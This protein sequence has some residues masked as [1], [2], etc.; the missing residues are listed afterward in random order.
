MMRKGLLVGHT[1]AV[2]PHYEGRLLVPVTN[3]A[4]YPLAIRAGERFCSL[5]LEQCDMVPEDGTHLSKYHLQSPAVGAL[6][7]IDPAEEE[8]IRTGKYHS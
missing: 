5:Y 8:L 7:E 4:N 2:D 6:P 3:V 1:G